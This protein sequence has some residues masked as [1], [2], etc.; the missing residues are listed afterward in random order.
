[1]HGVSPMAV[2]AIEPAAKAEESN[3]AIQY[4]ITHK[5]RLGAKTADKC[6]KSH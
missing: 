5:P 4:K 6:N 1:M 3:G 2:I